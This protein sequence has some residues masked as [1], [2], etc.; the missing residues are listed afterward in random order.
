MAAGTAAITGGTRAEALALRIMSTPEP[1]YTPVLPLHPTHY[2]ALGLDERASHDEIDA[3]DWEHPAFH[4]VLASPQDRRLAYD[5]LREPSR[6]V[7]YDRYL[8]RER[9]RLAAAEMRPPWWRRHRKRLIAAAVVLGVGVLLSRTE[10]AESIRDELLGR[11]TRLG[12]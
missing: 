7:N 12:E 2:E 6:R 9:A 11:F 3:V 5:V 8:A 4:A 10:W 1:A